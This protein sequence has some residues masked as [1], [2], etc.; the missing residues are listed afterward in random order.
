MK[1]AIDII[2][3][4]TKE[5]FPMLSDGSIKKLAMTISDRF[6][7]NNLVELD[8]NDLKNSGTFN[9]VEEV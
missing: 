6:G 7:L 2:I 4:I 8:D 9:P 5:Q 1:K 3:E